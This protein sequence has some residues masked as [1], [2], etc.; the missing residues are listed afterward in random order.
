MDNAAGDYSGANG[1]TRYICSR[2]KLDQH[3]A[4]R[5]AHCRHNYTARGQKIMRDRIGNSSRRKHKYGSFQM[6]SN[7]SSRLFTGTTASVNFTL[8]V[9]TLLNRSLC[10]TLSAFGSG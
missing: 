5:W 6:S 7:A 4:S 3:H 2:Q 9:S 1:Q 10:L 8:M